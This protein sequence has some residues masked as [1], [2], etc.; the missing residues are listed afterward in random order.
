M[1]FELH[2]LYFLKF[3]LAEFLNAGIKKMQLW[4]QYQGQQ[5]IQAGAL[6]NIT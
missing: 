2:S 6:E 4:C 3:L 1:H 5:E